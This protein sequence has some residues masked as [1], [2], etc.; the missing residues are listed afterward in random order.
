VKTHAGGQL[1][2][3]LADCV[4]TPDLLSEY[5]V[6]HFSLPTRK[7]KVKTSVRLAKGQRVTSSIVCD[8]TFDLAHHELKRTFYVWRD[9]RA[10]NLL[11]DLTWLDDEPTSL[12]FG[13]TRV[14]TLMDG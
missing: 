9:L 6:R 2:S 8:L 1:I 14:F 13:A 7:S 4:A 5:F 3:G 11:L 10:A 12:R